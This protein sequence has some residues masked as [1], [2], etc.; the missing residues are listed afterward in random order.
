MEA[1]AER[2]Q[3]IA[4]GAAAL[5][6]SLDR[7]QC[8]RLSGFVEL[9]AR[10]NRAF[11]LTAVRDPEQMVYRHLLDS[12]AVLPHLEGERF[13]DVG[14]GA[15][16]PGIPLA[17]ANPGAH[18][19]LLDG[20]GKK[21][22]FVHQAVAEL[23]LTNVEARAERAELHRP[24]VPYDGVLSRAF[25]S[26]ADLVRLCAHL[27]APTGRFYALKGRYPAAELSALPKGYTV[28]ACLPL[29]VPGIKGERHLLAI[30]P[31]PIGSGP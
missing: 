16:L 1:R 10:W 9:L 21:I 26:L 4:Q 8:E 7:Q 5:G 18:F 30:A 22:R 3:T 25:G 29:T 28:T 11:N 31:P 2:A 12:L 24:A 6:V 15:G 17:V 13:V 23:G 14:T 20:N 19:L 27:V